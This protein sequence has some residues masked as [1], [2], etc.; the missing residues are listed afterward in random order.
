MNIKLDEKVRLR[1]DDKDVL[2]L[3]HERRLTDEFRL[4]DDLAILVNVALARSAA[5]SARSE[6]NQIF[7]DL[8]ES[9]FQEITVGPR[10]KE[11][12]QLGRFDVQFDLFSRAQSRKKDR[13]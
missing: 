8:N 2:R 6:G 5:S 9:D 4:S 3:E 1:L 7:I 11:G 10:A 12:V 13:L